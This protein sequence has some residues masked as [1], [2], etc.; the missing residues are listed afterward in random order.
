MKATNKGMTFHFSWCAVIKTGSSC[1]RDMDDT[2]LQLNILLNINIPSFF[3]STFNFFYSSTVTS[4]EQFK[5][6]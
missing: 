3:I 6:V 2:I 1:G 5:N 4:T